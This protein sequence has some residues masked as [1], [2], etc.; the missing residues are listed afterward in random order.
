M[1]PEVTIALT[2]RE[3]EVLAF[4]VTARDSAAFPEHNDIRPRSEV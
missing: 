3:L 1:T 2:E 4:R